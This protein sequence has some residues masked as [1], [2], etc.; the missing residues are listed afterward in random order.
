MSRWPRCRQPDTDLDRRAAER[1]TGQPYKPP[2]HAGNTT[3]TREAR[4][5]RNG[6]HPLGMSDGEIEGGE[7]A[8][9]PAGGNHTATAEELPEGRLIEPGEEILIKVGRPAGLRQGSRVMTREAQRDPGLHGRIDEE[10]RGK[11]E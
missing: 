1:P 11:I 8:G 7:P 6:G 9:R 5:A 10:F 3:A 4:E 2:H